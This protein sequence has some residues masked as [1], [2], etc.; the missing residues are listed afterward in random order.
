MRLL[1]DGRRVGADLSPQE[2]HRGVHP[3]LPGGVGPVAAL[4]VG[5][6]EGGR[7]VVQPAE[8]VRSDP[9]RKPGPGVR[10]QTQPAGR[11]GHS[12]HVEAHGSHHTAHPRRRAG[13]PRPCVGVRPAAGAGG[14]LAAARRCGAAWLLLLRGGFSA[15]VRRF[16]SP[17]CEMRGRAAGRFL[18]DITTPGRLGKSLLQ[19]LVRINPAVLAIYSKY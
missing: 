9:L 12:S 13:Y 10:R 16:R 11:S 2:V 3:R 18:G 7:G 5:G 1:C 19:F 14:K 15:K 8:V 4:E 17:L 6:R